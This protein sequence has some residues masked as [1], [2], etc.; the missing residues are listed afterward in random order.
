MQT[1][2]DD[3]VF[4]GSKESVRK[5]IGMAVPPRGI[6]VIFE[7]LLNSIAGNEYETMEAKI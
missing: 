6:K 1:F 4:T 7:A 3:Y 5:Q 2:T